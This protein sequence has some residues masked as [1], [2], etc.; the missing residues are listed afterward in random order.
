MYNWAVPGLGYEISPDPWP[1]EVFF[2]RADQ[3]SFVRQG[4]PAIWIC[5]GSHSTDPKLNGD[6]LTKLWRT[7][8]YHTPKDNMDQPLDF[9]SA[10]RAVRLVFL[11]GFEV[12]EQAQPPAWDAGDFFGRKFA[13]KRAA[14]GTG[15]R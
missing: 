10:A 9:D 4:V 5:G 14:A 3:Y 1:E 2:I 8:I 6:T 13:E 11:V 7:N 15:E 12:G